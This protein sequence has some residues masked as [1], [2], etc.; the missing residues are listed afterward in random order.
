MMLMVIILT[1]HFNSTLKNSIDRLIKNYCNA[2]KSWEAWCYLSGFDNDLKISK[3]EVRQT[4][5]EN[6]LF[7]HLRYLSMKDYYIELYKV[8]KETPNNKD[9]IFNLLQKRIK[10]NPKNID[11]IK[12]ALNGLNNIKVTITDICNIRDKFYAHLDKDFKKYT[13]TKINILSTNQIFEKIEK[14]IISLTSMEVLIKHLNNI[15]SREDYDLFL[16]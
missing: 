4:V 15:E 16:K 6:P 1:T 9:N 5:D 10:S 13:A 12:T 8:V 7:F 11:E 3:K 14:G 2:R